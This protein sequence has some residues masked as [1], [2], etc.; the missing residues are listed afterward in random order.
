[1]AEK[2]HPLWTRLCDEYGC[3]YPI[4]SF[5]HTR[6]VAAA[7]SNAG[8][9]G[10][11]GASTHTPEEMQS[12]IRWIKD[13]VGDSRTWGVDITIP[14]S[15]VQGNLEELEEKVPQQHRDW[16]AKVMADNNIPEPKTPG[17][18]G[19]QRL[20][21]TADTRRKLEIMMEE[22]IPIFA[23]GLGSPAFIMDEMHSHGIKVWGLIGMGRQARRELE[24]GLDLLIAQGQDSAGH[25]G[26][27]GTFSI[28]REV[29]EMAKEF[30]TP[31]LAA[32]GVTTGSHIVAALALGA[33]GVWTGTVWQATHESE[34]EMWK[35]QALVDAKN[36]DAF[37]SPANDGKRNRSLKNK[38]LEAWEQPDAPPFLPMPLQ[39]LLVGKLNQAVEDHD[40]REWM[41][42]PAGQG[43]GFVRAIRPAR[44]V[45]LQFVEE[46]L[47]TMERL[48]MGEPAEV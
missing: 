45:V 13:H 7:V 11:L 5:A 29:T 31:I 36:Q 16:I 48:G 39:G 10:I 40:M 25:T 37:V 6:D 20:R 30:D 32:G 3:E 24:A 9:I 27:M 12:D 17:P 15:Y 28:V 23:S 42:P 47:D 8:G 34:T 4:V 2:P 22:K 26:H 18:Y 33:V 19:T 35:K 14:S 38:F 44:E 41:S 21:S 1:M 43:V 46:A